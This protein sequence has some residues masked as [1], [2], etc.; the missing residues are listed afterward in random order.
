MDSRN[1]RPEWVPSG[2]KEEVKEQAKIAK[3]GDAISPLSKDLLQVRKAGKGSPRKV[4]K[5]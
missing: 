3:Q 1:I 4:Y 2:Y 5:H